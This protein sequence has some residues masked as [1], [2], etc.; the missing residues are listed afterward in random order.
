MEYISIGNVKI[1][2]TACLAPMASVA[3]RAYRTICKE[4]GAAYVVSE[5]I[6]VKGLCYGDKKTASLCTVTENEQPMA[7]QLFGEE[8]SYFAQAVELLKKFHPDIIDINMGCP[9][10]KIAGNGSGSALMKNISNASRI[11]EEAVKHSDCPVTVKFRKGWDKDSVNAVEFARA[12]ENAGASAVT[13]HGRTRDQMYSGKA[14]WDIIK[15]VK[16]AVKIPVIGN[17]DVFTP[18]DCRNMYDYTGCDLVM[19]GRGTYGRPWIFKQI[20]EYLTSGE[21]IPEPSFDEKINALLY[22]VKMMV[23]FKGER[24]GIQ[25]A[26]KIASWYFKGM[27]DSAALRGLCG[28]IST[29]KDL[30]ELIDNYRKQEGI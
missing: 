13:I 11:V 8:A 17:G 27:H 23:D 5:M 21:V 15:A 28:R 25:E 24:I 3:D 7:L 22:Q 4:Y 2:K 6:S 12:M 10:P 30:V 14:D 9:V 20:K 19:L 26:R 1:E 16:Q 29:Y 18:Q